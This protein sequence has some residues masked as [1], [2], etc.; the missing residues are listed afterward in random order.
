MT[1]TSPRANRNLA[2]CRQAPAILTRTRARFAGAPPGAARLRSFASAE[3]TVP[4]GCAGR[5]P[6]PGLERGLSPSLPDSALALAHGALRCYDL[7]GQARRPP[8]RMTGK[9]LPYRM[10]GKRLPYRMTGKRLPYRM[11]CKRLPY[12]MIG[13]RLPYR[14]IG[15]AAVS[16]ALKWKSHPPG[17][18]FDTITAIE[19]LD[20]D[21]R[22]QIALTAGRPTSPLGAALLL[23]AGAPPAGPGKILWRY[24]VE[25]MSYSWNLYADSYL[26]HGVGKQLIML[27]H[28]YPPDT[29]NGYI[30]MFEFPAPGKPPV[31]RW[32]YDF[33]RYTCFPS[34][35]RADLDGDGVEEL[36][37][38]THSRMWVLDALTGA[39]KQFI[40]WDVSPAN[41]PS[42]GLV[43][44]QDLN[45]DGRPDFLCVAS[46]A[47]HHEVLLNDGGKPLVA[48]KVALRTAIG[49]PVIADLDDDGALEIIVPTADGNLTVLGNGDR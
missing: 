4:S 3:G 26:P 37:V 41:I 5:D 1:P 35:L 13:K 44:F 34:L 19:D 22:V 21:G 42:Y 17:L 39:V 8:Y 29:R 25:P 36:C 18:N 49:S 14:M 9:R 28:A 33:D 10:I 48:W 11:T 23:D 2:P 45:G 31:Q 43:K 47:Q 15:S 16:A 40:Q 27:E 12:R 32:R 46:F 6:A 38:E 30:V 7:S 20:R 24:D